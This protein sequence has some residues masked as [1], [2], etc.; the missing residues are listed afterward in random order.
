MTAETK[1]DINRM[2]Q[3]QDPLV[4]KLV[5]ETMRLERQKIHMSVP[6]GVVDDIVAI[7]ERIVK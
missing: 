2:L 3:E 7:V 1:D 4:Q 6:R 5:V